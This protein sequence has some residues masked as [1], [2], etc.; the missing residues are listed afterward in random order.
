M[1][2]H[3]ECQMSADQDLALELRQRNASILSHDSGNYV[4]ESSFAGIG[5]L[6]FQ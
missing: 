4:W 5:V 1:E 6:A 3:L 2:W